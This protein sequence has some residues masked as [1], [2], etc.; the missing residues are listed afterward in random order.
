MLGLCLFLALEVF[1]DWVALEDDSVCFVLDLHLYLFGDGGVMSDIEMGIVFGLLGSVLPDVR[2]KDASRSRIDYVG[3]GV[4][5]SEGVSAFNIDLS[6]NW[7]ANHGLIYIMIEVMKEAFADL[8]HIIHLVVP[9]SKEETSQIMD[10]S[11]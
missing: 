6:L 11:S 3:S 8:L 1:V 4:E 10:L 5:G 7:L 9:I 2:T